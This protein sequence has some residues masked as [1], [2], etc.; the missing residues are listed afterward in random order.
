MHGDLCHT[1]LGIRTILV[2]ASLWLGGTPVRHPVATYLTS[3]RVRAHSLLRLRYFRG[4]LVEIH[5][6]QSQNAG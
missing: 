3:R 2:S 1:E 6:Y 4:Y 5:L